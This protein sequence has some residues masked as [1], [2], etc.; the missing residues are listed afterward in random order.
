MSEIP[1]GIRR[2]R[3]WG[4]LGG[5]VAPMLWTEPAHFPIWCVG[6]PGQPGRMCPRVIWGEHADWN[7]VRQYYA[8][9]P[10]RLAVGA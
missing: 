2:P 10:L 3:S 6:F 7:I 9:F 5:K 4:F 8:E 1:R